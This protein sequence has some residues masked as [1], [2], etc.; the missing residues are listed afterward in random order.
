MAH[1]RPQHH[2][3]FNKS[4]QGRDRRFTRRAAIA[5]KAAFFA[6]R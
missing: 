5:R 1:Y 3:P 6:T 4:D 2:E